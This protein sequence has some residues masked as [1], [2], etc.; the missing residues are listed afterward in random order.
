[1]VPNVSKIKPDTLFMTLMFLT[2]SFE[3]NFP[4]NV[5]FTISA[6]ILRSSAVPKIMMRSFMVWVTAIAVAAVS[7]KAITAGLSVF[8][9]NPCRAILA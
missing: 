9:K 7:Q 3:R 4:A 8:S 1:M 5:T 2:V 6:D